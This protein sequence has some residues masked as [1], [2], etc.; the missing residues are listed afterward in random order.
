MSYQQSRST[1]RSWKGQTVFIQQDKQQLHAK[2]GIM[3]VIK[4]AAGDDIVLETQPVNSSDP[5]VIDLGFVY[6]TQQL[7]EDVGMTITEEVVEATMTAFDVYP[8][9]LTGDT[10]ARLAE[11]LSELNAKCQG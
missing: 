11:S 10:R 7:K 2:G 4:E 9:E 1:C 3:E 6:S 5:N 8:W